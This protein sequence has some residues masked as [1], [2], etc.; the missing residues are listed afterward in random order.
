MAR[1]MTAALVGGSSESK[2]RIAPNANL[3]LPTALLSARRCNHERPRVS[4]DRKPN[5]NDLVSSMQKRRPLRAPRDVARSHGRPSQVPLPSACGDV[6]MTTPQQERKPEYWLDLALDALDLLD[7]TCHD[8]PTGKDRCGECAGCF[9]E[10]VL[11]Q[12]RQALAK[13]VS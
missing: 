1:R 2:A 11:T 12:G 10:Y 4:S 8:A 6:P 7:R 9:A 3:V 13:A 5:Q